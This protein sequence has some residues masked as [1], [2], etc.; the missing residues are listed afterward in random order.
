MTKET[1]TDIQVFTAVAMLVAGVGLSIA[2]FVV[3][4]TGEISDS[5]LM[6]TAQCLVYAG[7]ALGINVYI[8]SKFSDIKKQ[9]THNHNEHENELF[10]EWAKLSLTNFFD[11]T[12]CIATK[13]YQ[14]DN[15]RLM[16]LY[17]DEENKQTK[18]EFEI[19]IANHDHFS[20]DMYNA[21]Y[22]LLSDD[23]VKKANMNNND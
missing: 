22:N 12:I 7:S 5:V 8:N 19:D 17:E 18:I 23:D 6:F 16:I 1:R 9:L 11:G 2:G 15:N 21:L 3:P 14:N 10:N 20:V 4:P 13:L